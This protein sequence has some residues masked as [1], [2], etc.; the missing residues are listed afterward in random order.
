[1]SILHLFQEVLRGFDPTSRGLT[2]PVG[3][4]TPPGLEIIDLIT[5]SLS[6]NG[7]YR[8][9]VKKKIPVC[10]WRREENDRMCDDR[11]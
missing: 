2:P 3:A 4:L 5:F 8:N 6:S 9:I 1:M 11:N 7:T 10:N